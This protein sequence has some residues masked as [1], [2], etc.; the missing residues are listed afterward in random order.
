MRDHRV[1]WDPE[2]AQSN[3]R[4]HGVSFEEGA[5]AVNDMF[6][7]ARSDAHHSILEDRFVLV[8]ESA[9]W[10]ILT[11][12]F[13]MDRDAVRI[14]SARRATAA[15]RRR[16]MEGDD[17]LRD[18]PMDDEMLDEYGHLDGWK[19]MHLRVIR[20]DLVHIDEDVQ[21][22]FRTSEEVNEALRSLIAEGRV[23]S[24]TRK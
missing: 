15:E 9:A 13:T 10:R 19:R 4:K 3:L 18:T 1:R 11:V 14:I 20:D 17:V 6:A 16:Y 5:A 12:I 22:H 23:P 21:E 8:G 24:A 2:K 7:I